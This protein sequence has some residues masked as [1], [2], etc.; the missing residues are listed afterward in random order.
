MSY[1]QKNRG[2][3]QKKPSYPQKRGTFSRLYN[4]FF[5]FLG[6]Y[7]Y[8][9]TIFLRI[10]CFLFIKYRID[11][12]L[13]FFIFFYNDYLLVNSRLAFRI[14]RVYYTHTIAKTAVWYTIPS[15]PQSF[16]CMHAYFFIF[17][18]F[19]IKKNVFYASFYV[20]LIGD[21]S[22]LGIVTV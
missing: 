4:S 16:V 7:F 3:P 2:Y 15:Y 13:I 10:R 18:L 22:R 1:P 6:L 5:W 20:F 11:Y 17:L 12:V 21:N 19:L 9:F 8:F 14:W